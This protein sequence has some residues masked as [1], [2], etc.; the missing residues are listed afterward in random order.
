MGYSPWGHQESDTTERPQHGDRIFAHQIGQ[1]M[2][3]SVQ[4]VGSWALSLQG[5]KKAR[6]PW[7]KEAWRHLQ[8]CDGG[9][10]SRRDAPLANFP[11]EKSQL[12]CKACFKQTSVWDKY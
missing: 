7:Q 8:S 2:V 9:T 3:I 1:V 10:L 11:T 5:R 4:A 6:C 12:C